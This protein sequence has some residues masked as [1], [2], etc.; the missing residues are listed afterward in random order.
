M[1]AAASTPAVPLD[2]LAKLDLDQDAAKPAAQHGGDE[3]ADA[4]DDDDDGDDDADPAGAP[5]DK[6][7]KK[8][9]PKKKS[10]KAAV[11]QTDPPTVP[12]SRFFKDGNYPVGELHDY[13]GNNSW[14]TTSEEMRHKDR[15]MLDEPSDSAF[16]YNAVR[17]AAEVHRQVRQYARA[18]IQPGM[19]MTEIADMIENGTRALVEENGMQAGIGFPTG[20][21]RNHCAA[22]YT[23]NAGDT[24]VLQKEDVLKVDFG[25]HV[26]GRIVDSAFTLNWEPTYDAL[27]AAVKDAT[28]TG[29]REAGIDVRMGDIGR[30]IQEVMESYEVEVEG[31]TKQVKSI[32]NLTGHSINPFVIH[33]GKSVPIVAPYDDDPDNDQKMEEGEYFAIETFGSTGDGYVRNADNCSHYARMDGVKAPLRFDSAKKLLGVIDKQF[34]TLPWCK[35]YLDRLGEK[36]YAVGLREL[37]Q[38]GIVQDYPPLVDTAGPGCQTAQYEHTIILRPNCKEIVTRG[39]DY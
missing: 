4:P 20:L 37:V 1:A 25:V 28:E 12:V 7:K 5:A 17:R 3:P 22:H 26:N 14:R 30:A 23:P 19:G 21:S 38:T 33:G 35:R 9:K 36:N 32:R 15:L 29:V 39:D 10:K 18:H 31:K 16:N 11:K 24:I 8:K 27:L 34:G 2:E 6:K 13:V